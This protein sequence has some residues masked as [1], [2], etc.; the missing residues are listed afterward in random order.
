MNEGADAEIFLY[1]GFRK[2]A[3]QTRAE[4]GKGQARDLLG[5]EGLSSVEP[6]DVILA[7]FVNR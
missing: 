1:V 6:S 5:R 2:P 3:V 7:P 4:A